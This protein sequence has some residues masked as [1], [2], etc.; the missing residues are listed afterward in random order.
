METI[1]NGERPWLDIRLSEEI[2]DYLRSLFDNTTEQSVEQNIQTYTLGTISKSDLVIDSDNWFYKNVLK[3]LAEHLYYKVWINYYN[4]KS[5][6]PSEF[7]LEEMWVNYQKQHE[8]CPPHQHDGAFSFV[9]FIKIPTHWKE[10]HALSFVEKSFPNTCCASDFQF[11]LGQGNGAVQPQY[12]PLSPEDEGRMLFFPAWLTHQ[13]FPFYGTDEKRI[14][15]SGNIKLKSPETEYSLED[16]DSQIKILQN[17]IA[18]C[19]RKKKQREIE[20]G[21]V[22]DGDGIGYD[23]G[24]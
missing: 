12:I 15:V 13:V 16:I 9:V 5:R 23:T 18:N 19:E 8:F 3:E 11:L 21:G 17:G 22:D 1:R 14:T 7:Y 20:E 24:Q 4:S 2:I 6:P 10:Q